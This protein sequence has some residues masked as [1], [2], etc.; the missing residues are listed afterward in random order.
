MIGGKLS[1]AVSRWD[2]GLMITTITVENFKGVKRHE[3]V[4]NR[5]SAVVDGDVIVR[6]KF[7]L[8]HFNDTLCHRRRTKR[9]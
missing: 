2:C 9:V 8:E 6:M 5:V 7:A 3:F 1:V 4:F